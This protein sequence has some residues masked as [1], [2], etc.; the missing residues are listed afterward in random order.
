MGLKKRSRVGVK[1]G[2]V[3][4][5]GNFCGVLGLVWRRAG[6]PRRE[7]AGGG[8]INLICICGGSSDF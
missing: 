3:R 4:F 8:A 1:V 6:G 5:C 7:G 2:K